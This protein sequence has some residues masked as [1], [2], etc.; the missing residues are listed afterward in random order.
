[1]E[2][3]RFSIQQKTMSP[4]EYIVK[5]NYKIIIS[6]ENSTSPAPSIFMVANDDQKFIGEFLNGV[7]AI[8]MRSHDGRDLEFKSAED[9]LTYKTFGRQKVKSNGNETVI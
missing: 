5:N 7:V 8:K 6:T 4:L 9:L 2:I 1:M 3:T